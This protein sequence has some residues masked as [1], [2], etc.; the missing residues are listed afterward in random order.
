M[1]AMRKLVASTILLG[2]CF[3]LALVGSWPASVSGDVGPTKVQ[4]VN[5]PRPSACKGRRLLPGTSVS[6]GPRMSTSPRCRR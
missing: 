1:R 2:L 6:V 5:T 3:G 4:V